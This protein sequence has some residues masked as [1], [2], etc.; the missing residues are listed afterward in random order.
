MNRPAGAGDGRL[1]H[2]MGPDQVPLR[3]WI[4]FK[5]API[6]ETREHRLTPLEEQIHGVTVPARNRL[7]LG[8]QA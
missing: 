6:D 5:G 2:D 1:V 3:S 7:A 4:G 8:G